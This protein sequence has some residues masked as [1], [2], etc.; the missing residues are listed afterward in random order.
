MSEDD[1]QFKPCIVFNQSDPFKIGNRYGG[2]PVNLVTNLIGW[3]ILILLFL[4][5]RKSA[6]RKVGK[7]VAKSTKDGVDVATRWTH[8][9]F[10]R[11]TVQEESQEQ[12]AETPSDVVDGGEEG[13]KTADGVGPGAHGKEGRTS[14]V[15]KRSESPET[16]SIASRA[17]SMKRGRK[18]FLSKEKSLEPLMGADA[19]QYLRFQKYIIIYILMVTLVSVGV[20]L[21]VNFQGSLQGNS[22]E[23]GHTTMANID[24]RNIAESYLLWVHIILAFLLFPLSIFLMRRF[25]IGLR[26]RD[27]SLGITRTVAIEHIPHKLCTIENIRDHFQEVYPDFTIQDIQL[28]YD[29]SKLTTLSN[30]LRDVKEAKQY[31]IEHNKRYNTNLSMY[32]AKGAR[33]CSCFCVPCVDKVTCVEYYQELED[34]LNARIKVLRSQS[35][36]NKLGMAFV[37]FSSINH[38]RQVHR[39]HKYSILNFKHCPPSSSINLRPKG[40]KVWYAPQPSDIIWENLSDRRKLLL[41]KKILANIFIFLICFFLTTPQIIVHQLDPIINILQNLTTPRALPLN[42]TS[43]KTDLFSDL[44]SWLTD[45]LPTLMIWTFTALLPVLVAYSDRLLGHWTRS[46]E[47][48]AVMKKT[49][50]Y[51]IFMV[52]I[53]PTFGLTSGQATVEFLFRNFNSTNSAADKERWDCIFLPDSGAFFVNYVITAA[54]IG[55]GLELIRFPEL[56]WY[57]IQILG[58]RT[59]ADTPAIRRAI[60]Y[61]F[62]FGEQ[63]ARMML[64]FA[65]VVMYSIP[66][67]LIT[68]FGC[69]YFILKHIVDRHNLAYVYAPSKINKKIHATAIN[70]VIMSV[71]LLQ[72]LMVVFSFIRSGDIAQGLVSPHT[73]VAIGLFVLTLNICSAQIWSATCK[74]IS[75]IK[76]D[77]ILLA[78]DPEDVLRPY[79]PNVLKGVCFSPSIG[80]DIPQRVDSSTETADERVELNGTSKLD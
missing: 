49:F 74:K 4:L 2:I 57:L 78:E 15:E 16:G 34:K 24:P 68:P 76:Y 21:P 72:F 52:I 45:F 5:I 12:G 6:L 61:E 1:H 47:N 33:C 37:S 65:M 28:A 26:M 58:S 11:D 39:D 59:K 73:K 10:E 64:L 71:A 30:E 27:I 38:A 69:M 25:S 51:L 31:A 67:P 44:P 8:I 70:F 17:K 32:P 23:F 54:M 53:L 19:V 62:R 80:D 43:T 60:T 79:I 22:T 41:M 75:P 35:L 56:F 55:S 7:K 50:W 9:F 36:Q 66:C 3:T 63:Y 29:V 46:G 13:L 48:H 42:S 40:W 20:V 14:E 77:D 18:V